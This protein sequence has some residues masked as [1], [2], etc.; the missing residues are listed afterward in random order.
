MFLSST[1]QAVT[2][3]A[4]HPNA[5]LE[6]VPTHQSAD[7][8]SRLGLR[9]NPRGNDDKSTNLASYCEHSVD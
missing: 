9:L 4:Y 3:S 5:G 8:I 7:E 2:P 1:L 6:G